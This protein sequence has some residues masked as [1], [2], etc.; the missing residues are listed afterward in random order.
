MEYFND[1]VII[2]TKSFQ[3]HMQIL[4]E[5]LERLKVGNLTAKPS[6]CFIGFKS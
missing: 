6:K 5:F 4:R 1:D 2:H 3:E